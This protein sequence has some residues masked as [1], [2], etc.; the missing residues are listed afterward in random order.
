MTRTMIECIEPHWDA[1]AC[2]RACTSTRG[3]GVSEGAWRSLNLAAHVGDDPLAVARNRA[4][5]HEHL[6]LPNE[7]HWLDQV[8]GVQVRRPGSDLACADACFE[9]RP[10]QVCAVMTADCLPV[11]LCNLGGTRVAAA[12]AGWRG[13][14]GGVL[15][16]TL[17]AFGEGADQLLAWLGPAI[18][19]QAFEVGDEVRAAFVA[20]DPA[21]A[22]HFA[23]HGPGHW[24]ADLYGLAR[25]RLVRSGIGAV[26]GGDFCTYSEPRRF[27]S[28]RRDGVT[29]RIAS[30]IWLQP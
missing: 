30:L 19:P 26:S 8:H 3:G 10:G 22:P 16:Q 15:E 6:E 12:H 4:R 11:L 1:P 13:L 14:L 20:E 28:Y 23:E 9:D 27:F 29:G 5:L 25:L 2:V 21:S 18:G 7:P 17:A 24:L